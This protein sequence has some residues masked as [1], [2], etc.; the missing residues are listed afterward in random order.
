M[1]AAYVALANFHSAALSSLEAWD[2]RCAALNLGSPAVRSPD[3]HWGSSRIDLEYAPLP[4]HLRSVLLN[5]AAH[6]CAFRFGSRYSDCR[7]DYEIPDSGSNTANFHFANRCCVFRFGSS[8]SDCRWDYE[9]RDFGSNRVNSHFAGGRCVFRFGSHHL[10][11]RYSCCRWALLPHGF[12]WEYWL[13]NFASNTT[14]FRYVTFLASAW[15]STAR[16]LARGL[17]VRRH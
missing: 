4:A 9:L 10:D 2:S 17:H 15:P 14:H 7:W 6:C 13:P 12:R 5:F 3:F 16:R 1:V 8:H 11:Y